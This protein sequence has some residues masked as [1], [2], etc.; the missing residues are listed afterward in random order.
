MAAYY[1]IRF[2][3]SRRGSTFLQQVYVS[4]FMPFLLG[5]STYLAEESKQ[6]LRRFFICAGLFLAF[7]GAAAIVAKLGSH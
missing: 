7:L 2:L 3:I 1:M 4:Y 5:K 6:Y